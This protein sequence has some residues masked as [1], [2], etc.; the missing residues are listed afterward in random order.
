[1]QVQTRIGGSLALVENELAERKVGRSL[2]E[3]STPLIN[4]KSLARVFGSLRDQTRLLMRVNEFDR[5]Q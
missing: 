5:T 2:D 4:F 1:M 3:A